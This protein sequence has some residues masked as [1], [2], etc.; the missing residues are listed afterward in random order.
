[1]APS[2]C[3]IIPG[4]RVPT[5]SESVPET[6]AL[7]VS[8]PSPPAS[9]LRGLAVGLAVT[10]S[11]GLSCQ[12]NEDPPS[13]PSPILS[14]IHLGISDP[15]R[16]VPAAVLA[17]HDPG[18]KTSYYLVYQSL[19][20]DSMVS[21][22]LE[23][24]V[25]TESLGITLRLPDQVRP[26]TI[27][28]AVR[29][30]RVEATGQK[31][32]SDTLVPD[33]L[34]VTPSLG[35]LSPAAGSYQAG[36]VLN[37]QVQTQSDPGVTLR[38]GYFEKAGGVWSLMA[39]T[40]LPMDACGRPVFG[41]AVEEETLVLGQQEPGDTLP[42]LFCVIGTESFQSQRTGLA[43]SLGCAPFYRIAP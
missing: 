27:Y 12:R 28:Y 1:M 16:A 26:F 33:S 18:S 2:G 23:P 14:D 41:H 6:S 17:W 11:L 37:L 5:A 20:R 43:Q 19:A 13:L 3:D 39:D 25:A 8:F 42:A 24:P 29:S 21:A 34:T 10:A 40:C 35:I 30:V 7:A 32:V 22:S 31:L 36:R 38:I 15:S 4:K 9:A